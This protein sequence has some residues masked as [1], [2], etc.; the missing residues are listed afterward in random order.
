MIDTLQA[1]KK[2][3]KVNLLKDVGNA[4][5]SH[6]IN[7]PFLKKIAIK[8]DLMLDFVTQRDFLLNLGILQRAEIL[9]A[10]K[11]FLEKANIYYRVNRLI[12]KKEMGELFKVIFFYKKKNK[13]DKGFK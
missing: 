4:D 10:N 9:A 1:V 8:N 12:G 5:I 13:F 11:K 7:I 3:K 2:H 6:V